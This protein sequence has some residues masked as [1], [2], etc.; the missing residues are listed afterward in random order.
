MFKISTMAFAGALAV[1]AAG[2]FMATPASATTYGAS[3][4]ACQGVGYDGGI[5]Q[6]AGRWKG[7]YKCGYWTGPN[8]DLKVPG[9]VSPRTQAEVERTLR[10]KP[11]ELAR[12]GL[13]LDSTEQA[14]A[15]PGVQPAALAPRPPACAPGERPP[16][17][18]HVGNPLPKIPRGAAV[19]EP[20]KGC[21]LR[22]EN[23]LACREEARR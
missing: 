16:C 11:S 12:L 10:A 1:C 6:T 17:G 8:L 15:R 3:P 18:D 5:L 13:K 14:D 20:P 9:T 7:S 4:R 22:P 2:V 21:V 19:K 23:P